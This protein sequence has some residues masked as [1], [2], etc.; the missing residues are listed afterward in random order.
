MSALKEVMKAHITNLVLHYTGCH[1]VLASDHTKTCEI[2]NKI[3]N[4]NKGTFLTN[5]LTGTTS[6]VEGKEEHFVTFEP[7]TA[8]SPLFKFKLLQTAGNTCPAFFVG[9]EPTVTGKMQARVPTALRSHLTFE[10][11]VGGG[12]LLG[13]QKAEY[14]DT[15]RL[16]MAG[17]GE[18]GKTIALETS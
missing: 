13:G 3:G 2:E 12:L 16:T 9:S 15:Q 18:E 6:F 11:T 7:E 10:G 8:G 4:T 14:M 5:P 17:A 1:A